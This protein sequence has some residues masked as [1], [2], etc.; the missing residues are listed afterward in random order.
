[1]SRLFYKISTDP[2]L[3]CELSLKPYWQVADSELMCT[4]ARRATV[5]KKLDLSWCGGFGEVSPTE[6]KKSVDKR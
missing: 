6:F 3:Y 2:L 5:L 4:L 1:M